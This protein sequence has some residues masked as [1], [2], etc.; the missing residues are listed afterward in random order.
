RALRDD[1]ARVRAEFSVGK[2]RDA[3]SGAGGL[4]AAAAVAGGRW[5]EGSAVYFAARAARPLRD[6]PR[7]E[8]GLFRA[9]A[10]AEAGRASDVVADAWM[11]LAWIAAEDRD[12]YGDALRLA[13]VA[14][15]VVER[16]G[17]NPRLEATLED[18]LGVLHLDRHELDLARRHLER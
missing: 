2:Y 14:G 16:L 5:L 18:H 10:I 6:I 17:G 8:G 1:L 12:R 9:I 3:A 4:A 7:A 11:T 13:G 15:G